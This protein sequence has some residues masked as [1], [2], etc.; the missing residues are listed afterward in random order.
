MKKASKALID[1]HRHFCPRA[2]LDSPV[3][4]FKLLEKLVEKVS[5]RKENDEHK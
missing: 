2:P 1:F 4:V 3:V 5:E